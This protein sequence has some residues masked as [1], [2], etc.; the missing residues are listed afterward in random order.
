MPL[1]ESILHTFR[2]SW[3]NVSLAYWLKYPHPS[4]PDVQGF[5]VIKREFDPE[6]YTLKTTRIGFIQ[7]SLPDWVKSIMGES[8]V[9]VE[10]AIIQPKEKR[11]E[12]NGRNLT[13]SNLI[14]LKERCLYSA[15]PEN[16]AWTSFQHEAS[17][18]SF[19]LSAY[20]LE[21]FIRTTFCKN[22]QKGR[23]LM[24]NILSSLPQHITNVNRNYRDYIS[25]KKNN[26]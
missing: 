16:D 4:R 18:S 13:C 22:A 12:L 19:G 26:K 3:Q 5:D 11:M 10:E 21:G 2:H 14:E 6:T 25:Q 7:S 9:F 24:E 1:I 23:E 17:V 8:M 20:Y 15:S